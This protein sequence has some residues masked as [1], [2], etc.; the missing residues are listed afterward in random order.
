MHELL[1]LIRAVSMLAGLTI[2]AVSGV[3]YLVFSM[4][5]RE[6]GLCLEAYLQTDPYNSEARQELAEVTRKIHFLIKLIFVSFILL[7]LVNFVL[8]TT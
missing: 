7:L 3:L 4:T 2:I 1:V 5:S 6:R 8:P